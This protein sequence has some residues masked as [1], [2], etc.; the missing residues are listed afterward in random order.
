[1]G[2]LTG[3][4]ADCPLC[5]G[6]LGCTGQNVLKDRTITQQDKE[7][8]LVRI[9]ASSKSLPCGSIIQ[10]SLPSVSSERITAIVLDRGVVGTEIDLL[11]ASEEEARTKVGSR[12]ISYDILRLGYER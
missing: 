11:M 10:F 1:M 4:A 5:G 2:R 9:V 6:K 3:Y 12:Q 7:Y 8:G